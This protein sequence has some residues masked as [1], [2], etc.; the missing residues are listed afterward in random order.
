MQH[1][2][3]PIVYINLFITLNKSVLKWTWVCQLHWKTQLHEIGLYSPLDGATNFEYTLLCFLTPDKNISKRKA[4][5]F[6]RD[7]CCHL[8]PCLWLILF[9]WSSEKIKNMIFCRKIIEGHSNVVQL[10]FGTEKA[11]SYWEIYT[12]QLAFH[13]FMKLV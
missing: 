10:Y 11:F 9:H 7:R 4:L 2:A 3:W 6:N 8:A 12:V 1:P 5:A 13:D